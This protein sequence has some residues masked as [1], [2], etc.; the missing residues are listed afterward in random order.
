M[1]GARIRRQGQVVC[2]AMHQ[3]EPGD[4]YLTD[5]QLYELAQAGELVATP[6]HLHRAGCPGGWQCSA[7]LIGAAGSPICGDGVWL[8]RNEPAYQYGENQ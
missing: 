7:H 6:T 5:Q 2:A 8:R 3:P 1:M 4:I